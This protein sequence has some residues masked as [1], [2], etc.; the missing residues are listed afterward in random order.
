MALFNASRPMDSPYTPGINEDSSAFF[1][2]F[3]AFIETTYPGTLTKRWELIRYLEKK[4][5]RMEQDL[6]GMTSVKLN[7]P[8]KFKMNFGQK[9]ATFT[10]NGFY[11]RSGIKNIQPVNQTSVIHSGTDIGEKTAVLTR[12]GNNNLAYNTVSSSILSE[13]ST[14]RTALD[15]VSTEFTK[16]NNYLLDWNGLRFGRGFHSFPT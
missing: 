3:A 8:V 14:F 10:I 9:V 6:R 5:L 7:G 13:I 12:Y 15:A 4:A 16:A 2:P 1:M 11:L